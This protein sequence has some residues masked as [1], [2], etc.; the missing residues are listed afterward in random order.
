MKLAFLGSPDVAVAPLRAIV[1][2]G[3]EVI[4]V[5]T[6]PD[7][8]R[9]RGAQ[10]VP[11]PVK[12][13]AVEL[14]IDVIHDSGALTELADEVELGVVVAFGQM[15]KASVLAA[16]PMV[17]LH[18]SLLPRWRGAAPVERALLAGDSQTGVCVMGVVEE[19]DAGPVYRSQTVSI[20]STV[21]ANQLRLQLCSVGIDLLL[22]ALEHG[23]GEPTAQTGEITYAAK[24]TPEDLRIDWGREPLE[25]HR[26]IRVGNAWT[27]FEG[28]RIKILSADLVDDSLRI[29][30][31]QPEGRGP[32]DYGAWKR[33]VR[34]AD[35]T[36]FE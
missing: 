29:G 21:T 28:R 33:G 10:L 27:T 4:V 14:G 31:V 35:D 17:N 25:I 7:R 26:Q 11:T 22:D 20:D 12:G 5:V 15:I 30:R 36:W 23:L 18:F 8:R 13:A 3:H 19:L 24:I 6:Q 34:A 2:A 1:E 32:M 16:V 9:G